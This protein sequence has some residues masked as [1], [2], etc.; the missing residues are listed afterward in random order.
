ME[1]EPL[2]VVQAEH[3]D[4]LPKETQKQIKSLST[5]FNTKQLNK[6][7]PLVEA[8]ATIEGFKN[9]KYVPDDVTCIEQYKEAKK[10]KGSFNTSVKDTHGILKK[11]I[12][13]TG[14]KLDTIKKTF[15]ERNEEVWKMVETEFKPYLDEQARIKQEKEDKK[16]KASLD[17]I[18]E[19]NEQTIEQNIVIE[20]SK[21][22]KKYSDANQT[23]LENILEKVESYSEMALTLEL[24]KLNSKVY[25][26][27]EEDKNLLL[28][29]QIENLEK[30]FESMRTTC[31]RMI[32]MRL[33]EMQGEK[34]FTT[35]KEETPVVSAPS[36]EGP[37]SFP[38]ALKEIFDKAINDVELLPVTTEAEKQAKSSCVG[39][40][41]GYLLKLLNFIAEKDGD[42]EEHA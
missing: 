13:E 23:M 10:F 40:L 17:K 18:A 38:R 21:I 9:I 35:D 7:N 12:L 1:K 31:V 16:N 37:I 3:F 34:I 27:P 11:P 19:L 22:F 20:R 5:D 36:M 32:N 25:Q 8:M 29:D 41:Q 24:K 4:S 15:M 14:R 30:S 2:T 42:R 39:G 26:I 33:V 28:D 6:F